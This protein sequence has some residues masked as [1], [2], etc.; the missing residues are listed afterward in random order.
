MESEDAGPTRQVTLVA[1]ARAAG[2]S[3]ATVSNVFNRP[4]A[5][6]LETRER[7]KASAR[8]LGYPGPDPKGRLLRAGRV[9]AIGVVTAYTNAYFFEDPY[10]RELMRGI[11][12]AC[13]ESGS[14]LALVP[15]ASDSAARWTIPSA[16]VDGLIVHCLQDGNRLVSMARRRRLPFVAI[17][18]DPG[19]GISSV[20]VEDRRGAYLA[21]RHLLD[22]G[23][24][25]VGLI[26]PATD[27]SK[28][29]RWIDKIPRQKAAF[30][31][32]RERHEGYSEGFAESGI[33]FDTLPKIEIRNDRFSAA[34]GTAALL[35]RYPEITAILAMSDIAALGAIDGGRSVGRRVPHNLSVIGFDDVP[36]AIQ[37]DPKLTTVR[38]PIAE[39]GRLAARLLLNG[40]EPKSEVLGVELVV[41]ASTSAPPR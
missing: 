29:Y 32:D 35:T 7:V 21:A 9:N 1:V 15:G 40:G 38:Q 34:A 5:V 25:R 33:S 6:S 2:V 17:D 4:D 22:L 10:T 27:A 39:K 11:G 16:I 36:E 31:V 37:S 41:R 3:H 28:D 19:E 14:G 13:D 12:A 24:R 20:M 26:L 18:L 30:K 8:N 23:H